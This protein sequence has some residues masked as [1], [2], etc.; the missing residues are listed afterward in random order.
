MTVAADEV[1][2]EGTGPASGAG[3]RSMRPPSRMAATSAAAAG[4]TT[5][6]GRED[7]RDR[8]WVG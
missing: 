3:D 1:V 6:H 7:Q 4:A 2:E 5:D 8:G